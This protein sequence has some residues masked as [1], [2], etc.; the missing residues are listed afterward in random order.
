MLF[1]VCYVISL[2]VRFP[3]VDS[4]SN[5]QSGLSQ[6]GT[7]DTNHPLVARPTTNNQQGTGF[8]NQFG[9]TNANTN[10]DSDGPTS[11]DTQFTNNQQGGPGYSHN[12]GN[13]ILG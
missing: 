13:A 2:S 6:Y 1:R 3:V 8:N 10:P 9:P 4:I 5:T 11:A 12:S 7:V